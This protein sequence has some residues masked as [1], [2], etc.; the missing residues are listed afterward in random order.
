MSF[1]D[2]NKN[3]PVAAKRLRFKKTPDQQL[4][5]IF[6]VTPVVRIGLWGL[7]PLYEIGIS[8]RFSIPDDSFKDTGTW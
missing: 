5:W 6:L 3:H 2:N 7:S 8:G 4:G 1:P